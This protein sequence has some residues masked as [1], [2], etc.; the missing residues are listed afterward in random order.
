MYKFKKTIHLTLDY[1]F[2]KCTPIYQ[3]L[4]LSDFRGNFVHTHH[5]DYQPHLK[6]VSTLPCKTYI[7]Q[8]YFFRF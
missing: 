8:Y 3:I 7:L 5:K 4:L 6:Y 1:N 2:G